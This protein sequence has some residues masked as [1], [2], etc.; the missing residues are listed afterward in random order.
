MTEGTKCAR[1]EEFNMECEEHVAGLQASYFE[2]HAHIS[3]ME[4]YTM[5]SKEDTIKNLVQTIQHD[6]NSRSTHLGYTN[7][8][9]IAI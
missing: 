6:L 7:K 1:L 2:T 8:I 3:T 4:K 5:K 9:M